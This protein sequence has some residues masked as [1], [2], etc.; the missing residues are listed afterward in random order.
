[1][2]SVKPVTKK[3][4][5]KEEALQ[6]NVM[7][8]IKNNR[9]TTE[10]KQKKGI[11]ETLFDL[12]I[13]K[14]LSMLILALIAA[15]S[16][17][18]TIIKQ[19]ANES[20]YLTVYSEATYRIIN[21]FGL[22]DA[23]H[24]LWFKALIVLFAINLTLCTA[25]G[26]IR[27]IKEKRQTDIPEFDRLSKMELNLRVD[28]ERK[29]KAIGV[30]KKFYRL[31]RDENRGLILEKGIPSRLGVFII[32]GSII[33]V[34]VGSFIGLVFG[35]KGFLIL[36]VGETK[37]HVTARGGHQ[38]M[39]TL[40]FALKCKDFKA[41]Y[42]PEGQPKDYVS[43]V[44]V[45]EGGTIVKEKDIRVNDP[46]YHKGIRFYQ[47]SY[48]KKTSFL[49]H[50]ADEAVALTEQEPF[51]KKGL[52]LMVVRFAE[53]I[54]NLGPGVQ[55]AYLEGDRPQSRWFLLN[56]E[57]MKSQVIGGVAVRFDEIREESYTGIE[58]ARDPGVFVVWT[59][60]A[61]ML[62][63]LYVNFFT[64]YRR[65]YVVSAADGIIVAG[66]ALKNKEAFK[67][68]FEKLKEDIY[69]STP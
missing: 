56:V 20:E 68:E 29:E 46:L 30:L 26:L 45:I 48:G 65:V 34:L 47:S 43:T 33:T 31:I 27:F 55:I 35:F 52:A 64:Y 1:M 21:I 62:L 23:Y 12:F 42:Y 58:V 69:G 10:P 59:G 32:H 25:Q 8:V 17:L 54:H 66:Y 36:R 63:G 14:R 9:K 38:D 41:S 40:G 16:I 24:S 61:L 67:K 19:G 37:D 11:A 44:E 5:Q 28:N 49:F 4:L 2:P 15:G 60:F 6:L 39:I 22:D 3:M 53:E 18:G 7:N 50:V 57:K 51:Q 13:S